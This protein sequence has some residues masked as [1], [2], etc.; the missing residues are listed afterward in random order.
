MRLVLGFD[1][2]GLGV[3]CLSWFGCLVFGGSG[4]GWMSKLCGLRCGFVLY[5]ALFW[6]GGLVVFWV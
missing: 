5:F 2:L 3:W 4:F 1:V 6:F